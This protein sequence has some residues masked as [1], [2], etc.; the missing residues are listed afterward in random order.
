[1]ETFRAQSGTHPEFGDAVRDAL[2]S[3][4]FFPASI[5]DRPVR[6]LVVMPFQFSILR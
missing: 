3:M 6:Q 2:S 5:G 1:M 4:Q